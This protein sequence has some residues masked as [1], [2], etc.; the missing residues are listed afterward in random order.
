MSFTVQIEP[1]MP[2]TL[3]LAI[4]GLESRLSPDK[5][6]LRRGSGLYPELKPALGDGVLITSIENTGLSHLTG[7]LRKCLTGMPSSG[8]LHKM[9]K[10]KL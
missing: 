10:R 5:A 6:P 2:N 8:F 3:S 7:S 4:L 9:Q 1:L